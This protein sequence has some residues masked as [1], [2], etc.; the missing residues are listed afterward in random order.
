M[1]YTG[2]MKE[3]IAVPYC[4][5]RIFPHLGK[6][7]QFKIYTV[8]DGR[9]VSSEVLD[10]EEGGHDD[11]VL[12]LVWHAVTVVLCGNAGPGMLGALAGAGIAFLADV[13]GEAD[14]AVARH[15]AGTLAASRAATCG[16]AAGG[17]GGRCGAGCG[18]CRSRH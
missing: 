17:C 18:G 6:S 1:W 16:G 10:A 12:W 5:G 13:E 14:D 3:Q 2:G 7:R 4:D 11:L 8:E 15:L 9:V